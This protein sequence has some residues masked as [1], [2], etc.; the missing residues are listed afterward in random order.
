MA[1][2]V[3]YRAEWRATTRG[4]RNYVVDILENGYSGSISPI[5]LTGE[6]ITIA[7]GEVDESELKP[8]K[9]SEAEITILCLQDGNPYIDL[10]TLDPEQYQ[11]VIYEDGRL[12]WRGYLATG[13]YQQPLS[14]PPYPVR[15]RA[16]DGLA[17][18]KAMPYL[19]SD[20]DRFSEHKS[21]SELFISL[22]SPISDSVNVWNYTLLRPGQT[23]ATFDILSIS[24]ASIY[25]VLGTETPTY[26]DV[27]E[28]V[29]S[30]FGVQLFQQNG[31][32]VVRSLDALA[33]AASNALMRVISID[34][35]TGYGCGLKS[36]ATLSVLP[37]LREMTVGGS[38]NSV[39]RD[40]T[41]FLSYPNNWQCRQSAR[42]YAMFARNYGKAIEIHTTYPYTAENYVRSCASMLIPIT[43]SRS[44]AKRLTVNVEVFNSTDEDVGNA[45]IGLWLRN[46]IDGTDEVVSWEWTD[47]RDSKILFTTKTCYYS[48]DTKDASK[49][50]WLFFADSY[51]NPTAAKLNL[52]KV[53][54]AKS[55]IMSS[56]P[57]LSSLSKTS[58]T[59]DI[60]N[61]PELSYGAYSYATWQ[62]VLVFAVDRGKSSTHSGMYR[63]C[64]SNLKVTANADMDEAE[65]IEISGVGIA[66]ENYNARWRTTAAVGSE[67]SGLLPMLLDL[68]RDEQ[69]AYGYVVPNSNVADKDVVGKHLYQLRNVT[70]YSI[71]GELDNSL[72][73]YGVNNICAYDGRKYYTNQVK[74]FLKRGIAS[75][76]LRELTHLRKSTW[77]HTT[78]TLTYRTP[79]S[80][81]GVGNTLFYIDKAGVLFVTDAYTLSPVVIRTTGPTAE[82]CSGVDC[83]VLRDTDYVAAY[84]VD[85]GRL[86]EVTEFSDDTISAEAFYATAKYDASRQVWIASDGGVNVV[87]CDNGGYAIDRWVCYGVGTSVTDVEV[88]PYHKGFVYRFY[89]EAQAQHSCKWH[90]YSIHAPGVFE[91]KKLPFLSNNVQFLS[92]ALIV[93]L[94]GDGRYHLSSIEGEDLTKDFTALTTLGSSNKVLAVN[95]A[96][97]ITRGTSGIAIYDCRNT[98]T[99]WYTIGKDPGL[100]ALCNDYL[101]MLTESSSLRYTVTIQKIFPKIANISPANTTISNGEEAYYSRRKAE[102][103]YQDVTDGGDP[104]DE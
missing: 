48:A 9:S 101:A 1:Y 38:S 6:C 18:L 96:I 99:R 47:N 102:D 91:K 68:S 103:L 42:G 88:F 63:V 40:L 94:L 85:G 104:V 66:D 44:A 100:I 93:E 80:M 41:N 72:L 17:V 7:Y 58:V 90:C 36:D 24:D 26:Y 35:P 43:L 76:Q 79:R 22:L 49:G 8:I 92:D 61:I 55:T 65:S 27:L 81:V 59:L 15:L 73:Q 19:N 74:R 12:I 39:E 33:N 29:L 52:Q 70:S 56:R 16:N 20:G 31:T 62:P 86:A 21:I 5:Y 82:I 71:E 14:K 57:S 2:G 11:V 37:P 98:G 97:M 45:Y 46:P 30:N 75:V 34:N 67:G 53:K 69:A 84:G 4:E 83:V 25:D 87:M 78:M 77:Q 89:S 60:P 32:W 95:N 3:K 10:Y 54:L 64:L 13:S 28:A 51:T 23:S 50:E